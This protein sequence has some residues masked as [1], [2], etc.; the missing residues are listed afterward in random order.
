MPGAVGLFSNSSRRFGG[1]LSE[2]FGG[3]FL[4]GRELSAAFGWRGKPY[5]MDSERLES[6]V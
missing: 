5:L 4:E 1:L 6:K 2:G 3:G